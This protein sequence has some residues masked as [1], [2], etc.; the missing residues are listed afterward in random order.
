MSSSAYTFVY[1]YSDSEEYIVCWV[2]Q[3]CNC[4]AADFEKSRKKPF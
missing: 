1:I 2:Q 4:A 3:A